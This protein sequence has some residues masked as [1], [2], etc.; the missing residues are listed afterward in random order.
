MGVTNLDRSQEE[1]H[2]KRIAQFALE[3]IEEADKIQ[4]DED[5]PTEVLSTFVLVRMHRLPKSL[6]CFASCLASFSFHSD[7][8]VRNVIGSLKPR[9]GLFGYTGT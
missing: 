1:E 2:V 8:V 4:V 6:S 9:Y 3:V 5:K 7:P